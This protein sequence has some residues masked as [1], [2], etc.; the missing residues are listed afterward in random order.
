M[1]HST[2]M[3]LLALLTAVV[4]GCNCLND[5]DRYSFEGDDDM[6]PTDQGPDTGEDDDL[7]TDGGPLTECTGLDAPLDYRIETL[8]I[9]I[10]SDVTAGR[11]L[12]HDVDGTDST[13]SVPDFV[14]GVDNSLIGLAQALPASQP[15]S[16]RCAC[17]PTSTAACHV[18]TPTLLQGAALDGASGAR[19]QLRP[20]H[21][22]PRLDGGGPRRALRGQRRR[23]GQRAWRVRH[24]G[25]RDRPLR[26]GQPY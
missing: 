11:A 18:R 19:H 3:F 2:P 6:G 4:P 12:G 1:R 23:L 16:C 9:P 14:G 15:R 8:D 26:S 25:F 17:R 21:H 5:L 10:T 13:C 22:P 7:G 20:N 24:A